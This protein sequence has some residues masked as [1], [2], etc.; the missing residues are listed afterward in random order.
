MSSERD[1]YRMLG[2]S[3]DA[4]ADDIRK[5]YRSLARKYHP[6]V[7]KDSG[8]EARFKQIN[9]AYEILRDPEKRRTYDRFGPDGA[10]SPFGVGHE[11]FGG[12][13]DIFDAFFGG[14]RSPRRPVAEQGGDLR[15][16]LTLGFIESVFGAER[17]LEY[18][19]LE[20]CGTCGGSG[21]A[22]GTKPMT[23]RLCRGTGQ[24]QRAQRSIFGQFVNV[25]TCQR[26]RGTGQEIPEPCPTCRSV[27]L[28]RRRIERTIKIPAGLQPG[29]ELRLTGEG[30]HGPR[31]GVPGDLYVSIE[32]EAHPQMARE[33]ADIVSG[34]VLNVGEAALGATVG[35]E[36]VDGTETVKIPAGTQPGSVLTLKGK[37]VP[38]FRGSG[39]GDHRI[40]IHVAIPTKLTRE[41][42][43]LLEQ[44]REILP[45]GG[46]E[47]A[48]GFA[49]KVRAAFR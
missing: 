4:S 35:V 32:A 39:R 10:R 47:D 48:S 43:G 49:E 3:R 42:R 11:D 34:L 45:P 5:A 25:T 21:A 46:G 28:E 6:D 18:E 15:A 26:C 41:Q 37:G 44:L 27:G 14:G 22:P 8:A 20:P 7:S 24:I 36:T 19:R 13:G 40:T 2:V 17:T 23:C 12:F 30:D 31:G 38:H 1:Y 9:E 16:Q 33:G 29:T